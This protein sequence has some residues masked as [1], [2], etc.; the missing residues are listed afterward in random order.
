LD[1][2]K[3]RLLTGK[4]RGTESVK[5]CGHQPVSR[6]LLFIECARTRL[7]AKQAVGKPPS[8]FRPLAMG[9]NEFSAFVSG[10]C[11]CYAAGQL[12]H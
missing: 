10:K 9:G 1:L 12:A 3:K 11:R 6:S 7:E 8:K 4:E 2:R 5:S